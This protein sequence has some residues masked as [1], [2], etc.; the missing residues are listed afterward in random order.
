MSNAK[1]QFDI[2]VDELEKPFNEAT[3]NIMENVA[4][5]QKLAFESESSLAGQVYMLWIMR[6]AETLS[7]NALMALPDINDRFTAMD[8]LFQTVRRQAMGEV[9]T[10]RFKI[11]DGEV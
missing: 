7:L 10:T 11:V 1:A 6:M 9:D 8:E 3:D 2:A 5:A 4:A